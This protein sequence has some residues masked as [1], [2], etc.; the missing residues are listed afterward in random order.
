MPG[1][2]VWKQCLVIVWKKWVQPDAF[3]H[4]PVCVPSKGKPV[5]TLELWQEALTPFFHQIPRNFFT[6]IKEFFS[7]ACFVFPLHFKVPENAFTW[8]DV[9]SVWLKVLLNFFEERSPGFCS[10]YLLNVRCT[11]MDSDGPHAPFAS[12][13][14]SS[15]ASFYKWAK[16]KRSAARVRVTNGIN[17]F[18]DGVGEH[19]C[20][21]LQM[22]STS[23]HSSGH[24]PVLKKSWVS[25]NPGYFGGN[26]PRFFKLPEK[27]RLVEKGLL[28]VPERVKDRGLSGNVEKT[29]MHRCR[30]GL[31]GVKMSLQ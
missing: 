19:R 2:W 3:R 22:C 24:C 4:W 8:S 10:T 29:Q 23:W 14:F 11:G 1:W 6:W 9:P 17:K 27:V 30:F 16:H 7:S 25:E 31:S 15:F 12:C 18:E 5:D 28:S 21:T 20:G 13:S 26:V